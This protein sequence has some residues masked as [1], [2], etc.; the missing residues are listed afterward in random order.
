MRRITRVIAR[1]MIGSPISAPSETTM[2]LAC[3]VV[4]HALFT[5]LE[6]E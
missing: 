2:A 5:V 6:P 3:V 1:P 4:V